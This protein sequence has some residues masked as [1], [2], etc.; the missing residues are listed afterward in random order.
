MQDD[1][2]PYGRCH[3]GC[4]EKTS[5]TARNCASRGWVAGEPKKYV[6][7]HHRRRTAHD[8]E[9]RDCGFSS[10]CW[11]WVR[12]IGAGGYGHATRRASDGSR[13]AHRVY[14]EDANGPVPQGMTLDHLCRNRACVNPAHL[15]AVPQSVNVQRGRRAVLTPDI[16]REIR[17]RHAEGESQSALAREFGVASTAVHSVVH[18]RTWKGVD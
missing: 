7:G 8:Y 5:I 12:Y 4:G 10:P 15:E 2:I 11:V 1:V 16:V 9:V 3:C 17:R 13:V 6:A 18:R 14:W